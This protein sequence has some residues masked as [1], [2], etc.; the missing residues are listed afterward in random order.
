MLNLS[1]FFFLSFFSG[2]KSNLFYPK[3][4]CNFSRRW[5]RRR[6]SVFLACSPTGAASR[7]TAASLCRYSFPMGRTGNT[8]PTD[9]VCYVQPNHFRHPPQTHPATQC[10]RSP[11]ARCFGRHLL[12]RRM[13]REDLL[14]TYHCVYSIKHARSWKCRNTHAHKKVQE[15]GGK[16]QKR[17]AICFCAGK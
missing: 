11:V 5:E 3:F 13:R 4:K 12:H 17:F 2:K 9:A 8:P 10:R 7:T 16:K 1:A 15:K 14:L 6:P